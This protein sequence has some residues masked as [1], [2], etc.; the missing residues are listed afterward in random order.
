MVDTSGDMTLRTPGV[1]PDNQDPEQIQ[2]DIEQTRAEMSETID[3]IQDRLNPDALKAQAK[4]MVRDATIGKVQEKVS[5][6]TQTVSDAVGTVTDAVTGRHPSRDTGDYARYRS[7]GLVDMIRENPIPAAMIGVGI[8]WLLKRRSSRD[9]GSQ[10]YYYRPERGSIGW[11]EPRSPLFTDRYDQERYRQP[12]QYGQPGQ[13]RGY[14]SS[15]RPG[16]TEGFAASMQDAA[17]AVQ[18]TA[19]QVTHQV[20]EVAGQLGQQVGQLPGMARSQADDL[21]YWYHRKTDESPIMLGVAA[22]GAGALAGL[23]LPE[24]ERESRLMGEKR[25]ELVERAQTM[26]QETAHKVQAVA[27][28]VGANVQQTVQESTQQQGLTAS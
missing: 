20:G 3:A 11:G 28:E 5:N 1:E 7:S 10:P 27:E 6:A 15:R 18:E 14:D 13:Y 21:R 16:D 4:E 26:A 19:G 25:D 12:E 2:D 9:F 24:T 23:L 17:G 22:I 8:G